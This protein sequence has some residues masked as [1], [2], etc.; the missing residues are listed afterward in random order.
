MTNVAR[1]SKTGIL[2]AYEFD[3][4]TNSSFSVSK[5]STAFSNEL[6]EN[7]STTL[8]SD[9]RMSA[10]SSGGVIVLDS[11]NEIDP[12]GEIPTD[13]LQLHLDSDSGITSAGASTYVWEDISG[14]NRD[15]VFNGTTDP[16]NP[17]EGNFVD[18][19]STNNEYAVI[20]GSTTGS[21]AYAGVVGTSARS[22]V[23]GFQLDS[24]GGINQRLFSYGNML[25]GNRFTLRITTTNF[26]RVELGNG[27]TQTTNTIGLGKYVIVVT[28]P[29]SPTIGDIR[30]WS[31]GVE[32]TLS[33]LNPT[34]TFNTAFNN[35]VSIGAAQHETV[36]SYISGQ[37]SKVMIYNR[38]LS[39]S[40]IK[41]IY[42]SF[43]R[44]LV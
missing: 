44:R 14:N 5:E 4:N 39:D 16:N 11:I 33:T 37:F 29:A 40:E 1:L 17:Q 6:D 25:S 31:N 24:V 20:D 2:Y 12:Y 9:Q 32:Q 28:V 42:Q 8:S 23:V 7:T 13:G 26:F 21:S 10:T 43:Y 41:L 27:Y 19:D 22:V 36:P 3:D 34:N 15:A 18:F 30:I 38:E 35:N